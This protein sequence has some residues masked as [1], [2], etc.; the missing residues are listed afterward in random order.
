MF[1]QIIMSKAGLLLVFS[2]TQFCSLVF[3]YLKNGNS[4]LTIVPA[5]HLGVTLDSTF[6]HTKSSPSANIF[7]SN[8]KVFLKSKKSLQPSFLP[9]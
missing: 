1:T 6:L 8:F 2:C 5:K 3:P 7:I 9:S 4:T